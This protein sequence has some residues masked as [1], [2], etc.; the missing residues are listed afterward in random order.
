MIKAAI[1]AVRISSRPEH[2]MEKTLKDTEENNN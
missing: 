1:T 2:P